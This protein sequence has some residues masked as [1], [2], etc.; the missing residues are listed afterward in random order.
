M[1][2]AANHNTTVI[3]HGTR[4][5]GEMSFEGT[6]RILGDFEGK[7]TSPGEVQIGETATC[8]A[9]IEG[10]VVVVDGVIEGNITARQR[11]QLNPSA[12]VAGDIVA[13]SMNVVEGAS[14]V[15]HCRIG[16]EFGSGA[17]A[18]ARSS[19]GESS[20]AKPR[21]VMGGAVAGKSGATEMETSLAGLES[22]I[23]GLGRPKQGGSGE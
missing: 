11:L 12:R 9:A 23:A 17:G 3:G 8:K 4:I 19:A 10:S 21:I 22:K 2:E 20:P 7:I 5:K 13:T 14:L 18:S 15:G 16:G 6:A 1:A